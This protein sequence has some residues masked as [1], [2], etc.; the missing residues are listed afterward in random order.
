MEFIH[1]IRIY[2]LHRLEIG[3]PESVRLG[4]GRDRDMPAV[5][6]RRGTGPVHLGSLLRRRHRQP[7]KA[8]IAGENRS[9]VAA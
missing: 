4:T 1:G 5:H 3:R 9:L 2:P 7:R 8:Q 6:A